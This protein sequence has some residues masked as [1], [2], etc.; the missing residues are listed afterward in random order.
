MLIRICEVIPGEHQLPHVL[1]KASKHVWQLNGRIE[2][3]EIK[4]ALA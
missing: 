4:Q 1:A 2:L 3:S